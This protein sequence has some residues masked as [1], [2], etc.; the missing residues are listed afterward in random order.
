MRANKHRA[1]ASERGLKIGNLILDND[2]VMPAVAGYSDVG[3]RVLAYRYGA[4]LAHTEMISAKGLVY[5]SDNTAALL[6]TDPREK[7]LAVQ[8]FGSE[9]E[10]IAKAVKHPA[11]KKFEL[12]DLN[13]GC[14][15]PKIVRNGEGSA[16]MRDPVRLKE[17]VAAAVESAGDRPVTAKIRAGFSGEERNAP[18]IAAVIESAGAA[19]VTVHGR[20]RDMYYSGKSDREII[21]RVKES[22]SIP[23]I[24]NGDVTDRDSY[25]RTLEETGADGVAVARAAMGR[26]YIFAEI[27][28]ETPLIDRGALIKEHFEIISAVMPEKVAV[29]CMKKHIAAYAYGLR[30]GK[31]LKLKA[32]AATSAED[33]YGVAEDFSRLA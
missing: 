1:M 30:G 31:E 27:G 11:V 7:I 21:K 32:F 18:E 16:L 25:L 4:A 15:V 33:I 3:Q 29:N 22:V 23:V 5:G 6:A 24:A 2:L 13:F 9:P 19:A 20:T 8:L 14:P 10:F 12:I 28:G 26:P 17:V